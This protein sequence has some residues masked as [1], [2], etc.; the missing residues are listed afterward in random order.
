MKL[1]FCLKCGSM[2][3]LSLAK[4][5]CCDCGEVRG[6]YI[7]EREAVTNGKGLD[8]GIGTGDLWNKW[9]KILKDDKKK[10]RKHY[11]EEY[12]LIAW[13]RPHEGIGNPNTKVEEDV[14]VE[15]ED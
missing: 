6:K 3:S 2:F 8:I 1:L 15:I 13:V 10:D 14:K 9:M 5:K 4:E 7:N 12:Q 11:Q